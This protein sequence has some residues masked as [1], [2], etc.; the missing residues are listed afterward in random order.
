LDGISR[1]CL[2]FLGIGCEGI[3]DGQGEIKGYLGHRYQFFVV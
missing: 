3:K 1:G 2:L